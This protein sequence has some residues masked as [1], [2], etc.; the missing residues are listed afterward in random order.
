MEQLKKHTGLW[1]DKK[2]IDSNLTALEM[3]VLSDIMTIC[4]N[5][6]NKYIKL[7]STISSMWNISIRTVN[8]I[9]MSL[10]T[11]ELIYIRNTTYVDSFKKKRT[12][13]PN[14]DEINKL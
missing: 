13:I 1:I 4:K 9:M 10:K 11:K 8:N 7:N 12:I 2:I 5:N 14:W 3:L 6:N